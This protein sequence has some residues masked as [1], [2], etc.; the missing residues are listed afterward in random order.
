MKLDVGHRT[1]LAMS[2]SRWHWR[3]FNVLARLFGVG[4]LVVGL[5]GL[6]QLLF[7]RAQG[8]GDVVLVLA[9]CSFAVVVGILV[10]LVKP[11]RPDLET[12]TSARRT[13][14]TGEPK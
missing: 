14:W 11:Y 3:T 8:E 9:I 10:I 12:Q 5:F 6:F 13:W 4:F 7:V 1:D 2:Y